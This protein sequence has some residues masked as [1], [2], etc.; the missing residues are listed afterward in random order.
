MASQFVSNA[1]GTLCYCHQLSDM[2]KQQVAFWEAKESKKVQNNDRRKTGYQTYINEQYGFLK[3]GNCKN[4]QYS[5][6]DE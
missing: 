6:M 3:N 4:L 1:G 5:V 2:V